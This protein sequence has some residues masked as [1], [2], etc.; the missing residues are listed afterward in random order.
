[1]STRVKNYLPTLKRIRRLGEKARRDYV[2]KCDN[3]FIHCVSECAKNLI[4]GNVP[5]ATH[6]M[7]NLRRRRYDLRALSAKKTSLQKKKKILQNG[8]FLTTLLPPVLTV[9]DN[10]LMQHIAARKTKDSAPRRTT[11]SD[12]GYSSD[13]E[14][15]QS[16]KKLV[17]VDEFDREYKRLQRPAAAVAKT[18]HSLHLTNTLRNSSLTDDRKVKQYVEKFIRISTSTIENRLPSSRLQQSIGLRNPNTYNRENKRW[19]NRKKRKR[20]RVVMPRARYNGTNI[21]AF[22]SVPRAPGS[23]SSVR[24]LQR[25]SGRSASEVKKFLSGRD[26]YTMHKPR[27]I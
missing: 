24:N 6:Q 19:R 12:S 2:R 3:E 1:M 16:A 9:L 7:K 27:R 22:Y 23:F 17:L 5:L 13:V 20:K 10:L 21:D 8:G 25:Y 4:K 15:I 14:L 26:A 18:N 11:S